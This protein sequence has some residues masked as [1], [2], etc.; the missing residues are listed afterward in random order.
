MNTTKKKIETNLYS[1][2]EYRQL[3]ANASPRQ[4]SA[5]L[6]QWRE[7][8][9]NEEL[10][11]I[12]AETGLDK[13]HKILIT[14]P[15]RNE[16]NPSF[17]LSTKSG[18]N[19]FIFNDFGGSGLNGGGAV[20]FR[21]IQMFGHQPTKEDEEQFI[22]NESLQRGYKQTL[23][24]GGVDENGNKKVYVDPVQEYAQKQKILLGFM[25]D[26]G[27]ISLKTPVGFPDKPYLKKV[28]FNLSEIQAV[29]PSPE[30][31]QETLKSMLNQ[32]FEVGKF[33]EA[34]NNALAFSLSQIV[35]QSQQNAFLAVFNEDLQFQNLYN[36]STGMLEMPLHKFDKKISPL[37]FELYMRDEQEYSIGDKSYHQR[38]R[39]S[40][41]RYKDLNELDAGEVI[42]TTDITHYRDALKEDL[43]VVIIPKGFYEQNRNQPQFLFNLDDKNSYLPLS[44]AMSKIIENGNIGK[45]KLDMNFHSLP[46]VELEKMLNTIN[47]GGHQ[48]SELELNKIAQTKQMCDWY[49][50]CLTQ[51]PTQKSL[52]A[53]RFNNKA[54]DDLVSFSTRFYPITSIEKERGQFRFI[55]F[56]NKIA[57]RSETIATERM[58][59]SEK[60]QTADKKEERKLLSQGASRRYAEIYQNV[61]QSI[62]AIRAT[63]DMV[64]KMFDKEAR[65]PV[66]QDLWALSVDES[67]KIPVREMAQSEKKPQY[68]PMHS[69]FIQANEKAN[70]LFSGNRNQEAYLSFIDKRK[71]NK[72]DS[73]GVAIDEKFGLGFGFGDEFN[74]AYKA[75][76]GREIYGKS[77]NKQGHAQYIDQNGQKHGMFIDRITFPVRDEFGQ[78]VAFGARKTKDDDSAKYINSTTPDDMTA[79]FNKNA[80][81]YGLYESRKAI[82]QTNEMIITEGYMDCIANHIAGVENAVATMGTALSAEKLHKALSYADNI[83]IVL[84]GDRAGLKAMDCTILNN[85]FRVKEGVPLVYSP[86]KSISFV[87]LP[88]GLDPD[89]H[90]NQFGVEDYKKR[91]AHSIPAEDYALIGTYR[92]VFLMTKN[93]EPLPQDEQ[94]RRQSDP[95]YQSRFKRELDELLSDVKVAYPEVASKIANKA[96]HLIECFNAIKGM[97]INSE[98]NKSIDELAMIF[99]R[100]KSQDFDNP[101]K[102]LLFPNVAKMMQQQHLESLVSKIEVS[103]KEQE[104]EMSLN[105][106]HNIKQAF[107]QS[108]KHEENDN[109]LESKPESRITM[110]M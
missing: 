6:G 8:Y 85:I 51:L 87:N 89:E 11:K 22:I 41:I 1:S 50:V 30:K 7:S 91:L 29:F 100:Q 59:L 35:K 102:Q 2:E 52:T 19:D 97:S 78:V 84:D 14:S 73:Q 72:L 94:V 38:N 48:F 25:L 32:E 82:H 105:A 56:M 67:K 74:R 5:Q 53:Y 104:P 24:F 108:V 109:K 44:Y 77:D 34:E 58:Q 54:D 37:N 40:V 93:H 36:I 71:L 31:L 66:Q 55:S 90:I 23:T 18:G 99:I 27:F 26:N 75:V 16:K 60:L 65:S 106:E 9:I 3:L 92:S 21:F 79:V 95:F 28:E 61:Q 83:K 103:S 39:N 88:S 46:K 45:I 80:V 33:T 64:Q 17:S 13:K 15:F 63:G 81:F 42:V 57:Q 10:P 70:A 47:L 43:P 12:Y 62:Q 86:D 4:L 76:T 49:S 110:K 20:Q 101:L 96:D 98:I 68:S 107:E 69:T